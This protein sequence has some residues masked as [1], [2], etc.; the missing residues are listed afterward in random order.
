MC[1]VWGVLKSG[2]VACKRPRLIWL[3]ELWNRNLSRS[4]GRWWDQTPSPAEPGKNEALKVEKPGPVPLPVVHAVTTLV[5]RRTGGESW[6]VDWA[7]VQDG[8]AQVATRAWQQFSSRTRRG[9]RSC[10]SRRGAG[11][12][13][14]LLW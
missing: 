11:P 1:C 9:R 4:P 13:K 10:T 7:V 12:W 8:R 6:A 3:Q 5:E 2:R 14:S